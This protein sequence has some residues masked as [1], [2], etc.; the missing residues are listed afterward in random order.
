MSAFDAGP[1]APGRV[2]T[3]ARQLMELAL[4]ERA[5]NLANIML[6]WYAITETDNATRIEMAWW[7]LG[8]L[9][10]ATAA[11]RGARARVRVPQR[12]VGG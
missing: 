6:D 8:L 7:W 3:L 5:A 12:I 11:H 4:Y 1:I 9:A 2:D 10:G